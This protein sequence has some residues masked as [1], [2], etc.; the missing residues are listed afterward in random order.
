MT[1]IFSGTFDQS[2]WSH[3]RKGHLEISD[4]RFENF[5]AGHQVFSGMSLL[6][7]SSEKF[8]QSPCSP[9]RKIGGI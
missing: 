1:Y 5:S 4:G 2:H 9:F 7:T 3:I 6:L 8:D